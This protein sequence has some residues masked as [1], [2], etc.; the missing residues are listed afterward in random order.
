MLPT[1]LFN[2][3][4]SITVIRIHIKW[5]GHQLQ[6]CQAASHYILPFLV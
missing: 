6:S 5:N 3:A 1:L 2:K 4:I